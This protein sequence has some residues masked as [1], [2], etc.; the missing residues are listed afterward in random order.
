MKYAAKVN[1]RK[2]GG[3][4]IVKLAEYRKKIPA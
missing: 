4:A 3:S 2:L 1:R